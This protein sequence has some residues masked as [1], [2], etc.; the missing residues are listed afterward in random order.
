MI[1][2]SFLEVEEKD[3]DADVDEDSPPR[4]LDEDR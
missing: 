2:R 4:R 3:V 1:C